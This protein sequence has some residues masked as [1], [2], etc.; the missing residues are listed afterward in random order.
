MRW[1]HNHPLNQKKKSI[2]K[3]S[4]GKLNGG[5]LG[6]KALSSGT[7][8]VLGAL[9]F[10]DKL[11]LDRAHKGAHNIPCLHLHLSALVS[12]YTEGKSFVL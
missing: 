12:F 1:L 10:A 11:S 7:S 9:M 6:R 8:I 2:H 3:G 5:V 4:Y